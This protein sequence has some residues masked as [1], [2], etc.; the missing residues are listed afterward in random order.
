[1]FKKVLLFLVLFGLLW[2]GTTATET[3]TVYFF[4]DRL[5]SVCRDVENFLES[6]QE[7]YPEMDLIVYPITDTQKLKEI[8]SQHGVEEYAIMSPTIFIGENFFQFREFTSHNEE[9][10]ISA[11]EGNLV[12]DN[13]SVFKI[14]FLNIEVD[15]T[16]LS[17][18]FIAI[19]LGVVDGF[20]V[21]S[22]GAL[23]L[24]LSIVMVL[25][26]RKKIFLYG[27]LFI[28]TAV[29]IYGA[30][31]FFWGQ[32][33]EV[34]IGQLEI[35]RL[36]VGLSALIGGFF[37]FRQFLKFLKYGPT[38]SGADSKIAT[39]ATSK[40]QKAFK[41]SK[42]FY[43]LAGSVVFFA[44][45]ITIVELPCSVGI[46]IAFAG[47]LVENGVSTISYISYILLYLFFYML[48]EFIIFLGAVFTKKIW[49][50]GSKIMTW[51]TFIGS[52][53]LFGLGLYYLL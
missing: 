1:M 15:I 52:M 8:A 3:T 32:L 43:I 12:E 19:V 22:V 38:C 30:L 35:L 13:Y 16:Q 24:V 6:I 18:P 23:I 49:F 11:L 17:L 34:L 28:F 27:G 5:C 53:V 20:N 37:F 41:G 2:T 33:F 21:C 45:V 25:E 50:S 4:N 9:M 31:V 14:P 29:A 51:T 10:L 26:S 48:D 44:T 39:S 7:N 47:I 42:S 36:L 46:P 40:L